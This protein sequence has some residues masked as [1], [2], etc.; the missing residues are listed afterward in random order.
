MAARAKI[1]N[2]LKHYKLVII[3]NIPRAQKK[4]C[5]MNKYY[6]YEI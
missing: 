3:Y 1:E 5:K 2:N 4:F 6:L